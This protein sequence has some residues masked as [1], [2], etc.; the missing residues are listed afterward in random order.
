MTQ[1]SA[2]QSGSV[3][4]SGLLVCHILE[5]RGLRIPER[6]KDLTDEMYCVLEIDG[7]HRA[8]TGLPITSFLIQRYLHFALFKFTL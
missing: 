2:G 4:M 7:D 3:S 6:Q 8:R 1:T 5:G